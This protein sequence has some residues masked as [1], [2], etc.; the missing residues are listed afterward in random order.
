MPE[1]ARFSR[2]LRTLREAR[3]VPL[4]VVAAA[5]GV[6]ST[7]LSKLECGERLPTDVQADALARHYKIESDEMRR[8]LVAARIL[9]DYGGDP[10]L[11][12]A[13]ALVR[14]ESTDTTSLSRSP[15]RRVVY[16]ARKRRRK[17]SK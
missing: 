6:D 14:E 17:R 11:T 16:T 3:E 9:H 15:R 2:W 8:R 12:D 7:L 13:I 10:A 5:I 4:R 1:T